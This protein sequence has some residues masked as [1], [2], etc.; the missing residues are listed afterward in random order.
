[1]Q[2]E[3]T[4][5]SSDRYSS[6]TYLFVKSNLDLNKIMASHVRLKHVTDYISSTIDDGESKL[7]TLRSLINLT[8]LLP[9]TYNARTWTGVFDLIQRF[10]FVIDGLIL[11]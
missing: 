10:N 7:K 9:I 1:M 5:N 6:G 3:S 11:D 8:T 2:S 4:I